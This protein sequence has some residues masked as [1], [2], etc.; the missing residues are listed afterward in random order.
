M[1]DVFK[2]LESAARGTKNDLPQTL[3]A[4]KY[5]TAGLVP[6]IAQDAKTGAV[7]MLAWMNRESIE[8][9]LA[10]GRVTYFSRSR[11]ELWRKGDT[12]GHIQTLKQMNID[13]DG[14]TLL[15]QVDQTGAACH[16]HRKHC[17]Y[18]EVDQSSQ[19]IVVTNDAGPSGQDR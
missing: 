1:R 9:T 15:L 12:S 14:D 19:S 8:A 6:A 18:L 10:S 2:S 16:T 13:C 3:D 17:F 11:N 7:L 4:L 5:N